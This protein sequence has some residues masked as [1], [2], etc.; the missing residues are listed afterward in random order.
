MRCD[1]TVFGIAFI[2]AA[3]V[4]A[5]DLKKITVDLSNAPEGDPPSEI[6]VVDGTINVTAHEERK[7]LAISGD[8]P[9]IEAGAVFGSSANGAAFVEA[10][11]FA[12]KAGRAQPKFGI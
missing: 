11:I 6:F 8:K 9:E 4:Q 10:R 5:G 7:V 12:S 2:A 1:T 3:I